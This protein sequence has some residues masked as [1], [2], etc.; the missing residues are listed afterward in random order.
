MKRTLLFRWQRGGGK[1]PCYSG[2]RGAEK[3]N[4]FI[5]VAE[6]RRKR[7]SLL[8]WQITTE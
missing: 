8:R 6:E 4:L 5:E 2:G 7:T 1:E 3:R